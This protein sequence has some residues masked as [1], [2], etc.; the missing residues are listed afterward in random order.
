[1]KFK[2]EMVR[3]DLPYCIIFCKVLKRDI[4]SFEEALGML[5]DKML[6]LG[7]NDYPAVCDEISKM[8]ETGTEK[9]QM[10]K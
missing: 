6:L 7:H 5:K 2:G 10:P 8:I 9:M 1:M 4:D 3:D